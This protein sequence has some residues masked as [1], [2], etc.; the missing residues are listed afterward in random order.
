MNGIIRKAVYTN[1]LL[2]GIN[3][4]SPKKLVKAADLFDMEPL[5][6]SQSLNEF[7]NVV[8][9]RWKHPNVLAP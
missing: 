7:I 3:L 5:I 2:Y 1:V 9:K 8:L 6:D 4:E